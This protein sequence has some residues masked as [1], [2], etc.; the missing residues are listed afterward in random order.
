MLFLRAA[1]QPRWSCGCGGRAFCVSLRVAV[2]VFAALGRV[3]GA[4]S[5]WLPDSA[6]G[7]VDVRWAGYRV[8]LS[9]GCLHPT[10]STRL[11]L[12]LFCVKELRKAK[13]LRGGCQVT[14]PKPLLDRQ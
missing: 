11:H 1:F 8:F 2:V 10:A 9:Q 13:G 12:A 4:G 7:G 5:G 6:P 3:F 14:T